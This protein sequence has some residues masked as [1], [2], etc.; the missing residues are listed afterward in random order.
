MFFKFQ[1]FFFNFSLQ[2]F[3]CFKLF[4]IDFKN[5]SEFDSTHFCGYLKYLKF[6]SDKYLLVYSQKNVQSNLNQCWS[7]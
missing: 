3:E 5:C 1:F 6:Y 4:N 7:F 2:L